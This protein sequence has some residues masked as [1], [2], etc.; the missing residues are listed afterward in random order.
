[1]MRIMSYEVFRKCLAIVSDRSNY[2]KIFYADALEECLRRLEL[3][4]MNEPKQYEK[5]MQQFKAER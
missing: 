4:K 3:L 1:M 5:W 2:Y